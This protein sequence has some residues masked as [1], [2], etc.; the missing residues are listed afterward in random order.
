MIYYEVRQRGNTWSIYEGE[1]AIL[2]NLAEWQA[3]AIA[4]ILNGSF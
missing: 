1:K 4:V 3:R 2:H